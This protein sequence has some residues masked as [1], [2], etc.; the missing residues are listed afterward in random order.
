MTSRERIL[1]TLNFQPTDRLSVDLMEGA[2]W[3]E[4]ME[5][6]TS[7]HGLQS[8]DEVQDLLGTDCR[9]VGLQYVGPKCDNPPSTKQKSSERMYSGQFTVGSLAN[10]QTVADVERRK[11]P[12]PAWL[13]PGDFRAARNRWPEH[14]LVFGH[15]WMPL[16]WTACQEFG[17]EEA[18]IKMYTQPDVFE[19]FVSRQHEYY[20]DI[21]SRAFEAGRGLCDICWLGDDY[22]SQTQ[23]MFS[24]DL[25]RKLIK[26]YLAKQV[27]FVRQNGMYVFFHSCGNIRS[28]LPDLIEIGIHAHLVFQTTASS[29]DAYSIAREFGG[30][31]AF[32]GGMDVQQLLS[33]GTPDDVTAAVKSNA[34]AFEK[35]G[36][37]IVANSHHG[38]STI[39]G[40][41]IKAMCK[42]AI[43]HVYGDF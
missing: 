29:M 11:W 33:S 32:Y 36:G 34:K 3:P 18:L 27:A 10:A 19:A 35:Y 39:K 31:L 22:A 8:A 30:R 21:L 7:Q 5:Y 9:W 28:I 43:H 20:M 6:F 16:F 37:Y 40:E 2:V 12:D 1:A 17:M 15:S 26:P 14:A 42:A 25:W 38:V 24:P 4:L 23:M 13:V 41:N